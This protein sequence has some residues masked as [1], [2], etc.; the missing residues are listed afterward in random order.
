LASNPLNIVELNATPNQQFGVTASNGV[1]YQI[2][3]KLFDGITYASIEIGEE[4]ICASIPCVA[5]GKI[6]PYDYMTRGGNFYWYS[7][8]QDYPDYLKF[9]DQHA[10]VYFTDAEILEYGL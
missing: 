7:Q 5:G 8:D 10:L 4:I 6:I 1:N 9:N 2:T 3:L